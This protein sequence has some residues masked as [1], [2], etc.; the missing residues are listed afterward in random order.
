[1][2][3]AL[4]LMVDTYP[5]NVVKILR[6]QT[7][8]SSWGWTRGR[9]AFLFQ[10]SNCQH[11]VL[12]HS[13]FSTMF[14]KILYLG[15]FSLRWPPSIVLSTVLSTWRLWSA[16]LRKYILDKLCSGMSYSAIGHAFNVIRESV[17]SRAWAWVAS[18]VVQTLPFQKVICIM[19][20]FFSQ[21]QVCETV[22]STFRYGQKSRL[23]EFWM[24]KGIPFCYTGLGSSLSK[25]IYKYLTFIRIANIKFL[26][27]LVVEVLLFCQHC[28]IGTYL[29]LF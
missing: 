19:N 11:R 22:M 2:G 17:G 4:A 21:T 1:M 24:F 8:F 6:H 28:K 7:H 18:T 16:L 23:L 3:G 27:S 29:Y 15:D 14:S 10:F 25:H 5:Y 9:F 12:F 13:L 26:I 20:G